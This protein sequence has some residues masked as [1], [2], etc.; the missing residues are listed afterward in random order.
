MKAIRDHEFESYL[1]KTLREKEFS[2]R[3]GEIHMSD[4]N[5]CLNRQALRRRNPKEE[6]PETILKFGL[7]W[8]TQR[9]LTSSD[10]DIPSIVV[11]GIYVTLD[12]EFGGVPWEL[13][14]TYESSNKNI[15]DSAPYMR[16]LM[17]QCYVKSVV[18]ARISRLELMGDYKTRN[19][20]GHPV[21]PTLTALFIV[22]DEQELVDNWRWFVERRKLFAPM[23]ENHELLAPSIAIP[24]GQEWECGYC[25]YKDA[26]CPYA[27]VKQKK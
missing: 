14:A 9:W 5:Y 24:A 10:K 7:G 26:E 17:A 2:D 6:P 3:T 25:I 22:F 23:L 21:R 1:I 20:D 27:V 13:K 4:L 11:D 12:A 19:L 18:N 15:L 16:Q 8:A